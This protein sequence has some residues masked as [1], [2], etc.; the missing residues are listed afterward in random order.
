MPRKIFWV[1]YRHPHPIR[2]RSLQIGKFSTS[3]PTR[4]RKAG[5]TDRSKTRYRTGY[6]YELKR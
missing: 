5:Y 1:S 2:F 3:N 4:I 6:I